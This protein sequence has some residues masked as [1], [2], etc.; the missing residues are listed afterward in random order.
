MKFNRNDILDKPNQLWVCKVYHSESNCRD[1]LETECYGTFGDF[2]NDSELEL[3]MSRVWNVD[4]AN[5]S[6]VP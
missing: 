2:G 3:P 5:I 4:R 6:S 1:Q